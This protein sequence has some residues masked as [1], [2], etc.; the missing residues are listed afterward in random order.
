MPWMDLFC[1]CLQKTNEGAAVSMHHISVPFVV[2]IIQSFSQRPSTLHATHVS[3]VRHAA[4]WYTPGAWCV[5]TNPSRMV[6]LSSIVLL[7]GMVRASE[8]KFEHVTGLPFVKLYSFTFEELNVVKTPSTISFDVPH[9]VGALD[10][11]HVKRGDTL[12]TNIDK[13]PC[14]EVEP[15]CQ[16]CYWAWSGHS[17]VELVTDESVAVRP[18][19]YLGMHTE[20]NDGFDVM[21]F[22]Y[23]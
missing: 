12:S 19:H 2:S 14:P 11:Q 1:R 10:S 8:G 23:R 17:F 20:P 5:M 18:L 3:T 22:T 16:S 15:L 4:Q 6:L 21:Q 13:F 7:D 9:L